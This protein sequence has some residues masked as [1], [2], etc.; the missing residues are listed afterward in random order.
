MKSLSYE[1]AMQITSQREADEYFEELVKAMMKA[2]RKS[3]QETVKIQRS[4]LAYFAGYYDNETRRRVEKLF[5][6]KHPIFGSIAKKGPPT[7]EQVFEMG[8]KM[9]ERTARPGEKRIKEWVMEEAERTGTTA[10][11]IYAKMSRGHYKDRITVRKVNYQVGFI[12]EK[13]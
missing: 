8:K 2:G 4:N 9:G 13:K 5:K 11:A 7:N 6:C 10:G 12:K 1:S 3:R